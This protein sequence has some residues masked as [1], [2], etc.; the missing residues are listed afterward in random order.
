MPSEKTMLAKQE[1][2]RE[3][4][5]KL[6]EAKGMV[7]ADYRGLTVEQDTKLRKELREAGIDYQVI[8]NSIIHFA[9]KDA[10]L[11]E[12]EPYLN[13]P[14]AL[15]MSSVDPV[16]PSKLLAKFEKSFE[17]FE[18]KAGVVEGKVVDVE[19]VKA[20]SNLPSKEELIAKMLGSL[21]SPINGFVNVLNG[22]M[23]GLVVALNAVAEKK[24]SA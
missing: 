3:L 4:A 16:A 15:A 24:Q 2:V 20:I 21:K 9:A 17:K 19:G 18:L 22:N 11:E 5:Q 14:T 1:Q 23:R 7:L 8:K 6:K 13:G 12:L 10:G